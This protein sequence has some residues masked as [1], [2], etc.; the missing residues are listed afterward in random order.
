MENTKLS[1]EEETEMNNLIKRKMGYSMNAQQCSTCNYSSAN[2]HSLSDFT[3]S[4]NQSVPL[5]V[6]SN[7]KCNHWIEKGE[8]KLGG[9]DV[10]VEQPLGG[11]PIV[12][13]TKKIEPQQLN[14]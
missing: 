5:S 9:Q 11:I 6:E 12:D 2:S 10:K 8:V 1:F 4:F 14:S 13:L 3:C 7:G